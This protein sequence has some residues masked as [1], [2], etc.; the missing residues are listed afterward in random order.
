MSTNKV[1]GDRHA[2]QD[3]EFAHFH[4]KKQWQVYK[5][6]T[7][8]AGDEGGGLPGEPTFPHLR[9]ESRGSLTCVITTARAQA[10]AEYG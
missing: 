10:S 2:R 8:T 3:A 5:S 1:L 9:D 7:A 6:G 4:L